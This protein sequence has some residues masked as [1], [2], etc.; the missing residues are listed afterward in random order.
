MCTVPWHSVRLVFGRGGYIGV[1]KSRTWSKHHT[2]IMDSVSRESPR[3]SWPR[4]QED[5][6]GT[7]SS[8]CLAQLLSPRLPQTCPRNT[9]VHECLHEAGVTKEEDTFLETPDFHVYPRVYGALAF[10][11]GAGAAPRCAD[12]SLGSLT[13]ACTRVHGSLAFGAFGFWPRGVHRGAKLKSME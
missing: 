12:L 3:S 1:R 9:G 5:R 6:R 4:C 11:A 10:G 2:S 8:P 7:T 13:Y